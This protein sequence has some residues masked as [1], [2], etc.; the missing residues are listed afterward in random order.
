MEARGMPQGPIV[1]QCSMP[2]TAEILLAVRPPM[3]NLFRAGI[4]ERQLII[5]QLRAPVRAKRRDSCCF[6]SV[7]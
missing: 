2:M 1:I 5:S 7:L 6:L 3:S 4:P